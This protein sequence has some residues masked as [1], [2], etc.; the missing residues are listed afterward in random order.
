MTRLSAGGCLN[1][2]HPSALVWFV[3]VVW[4]G[5]LS[6]LVIQTLESSSFMKR[7]AVCS[8]LGHLLLRRMDW[9][10]RDDCLIPVEI[11]FF[12]NFTRFPQV[13]T[14]ERTWSKSHPR[15]IQVSPDLALPWSCETWIVRKQ[16]CGDDG[17]VRVL[18]LSGVKRNVPRSMIQQDAC[19][20]CSR[21][22]ARI[23]SLFWT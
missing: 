13:E 1:F 23:I 3:V 15:T 9:I 14:L 8:V 16:K 10:K 18:H 11:F 7:R 20:S 21:L 22:P 12:Y 17:I 5:L 4:C 2:G 19:I 6:F